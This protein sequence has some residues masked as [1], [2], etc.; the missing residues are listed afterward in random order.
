VCLVAEEVALFDLEVDELRQ[1]GDTSHGCLEKVNTMRGSAYVRPEAAP[2][3][4][5]QAGR[6]PT[7]PL[8]KTLPE[9]VQ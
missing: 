4:A 7:G 2:G 8:H 9:I 3:A 6:T 5:Q 1:L